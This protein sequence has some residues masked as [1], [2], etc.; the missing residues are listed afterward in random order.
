MWMFALGVVTGIGLT[1]FLLVMLVLLEDT[2]D[3]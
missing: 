3:A 2:F 1:A